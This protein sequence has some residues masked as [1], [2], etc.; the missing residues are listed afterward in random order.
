[1][2]QRVISSCFLQ[3]IRTAYMVIECC[4]SMKQIYM[5]TWSSN[6]KNNQPCRRTYLRKQIS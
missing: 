5:K 3:S 1:M 6:D 2:N 4:I